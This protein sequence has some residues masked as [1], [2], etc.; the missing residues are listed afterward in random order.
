ME[1]DPHFIRIFIKAIVMLLFGNIQRF[2]CF[3]C[4]ESVDRPSGFTTVIH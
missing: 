3:E 2:D 4:N 1:R